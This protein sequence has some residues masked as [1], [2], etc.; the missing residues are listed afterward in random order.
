MWLGWV[1]L[2]VGGFVHGF[3]IGMIEDRIKGG[4]VLIITGIS[5]ALLGMAAIAGSRG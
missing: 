5:L 2:A 1:L 3:G 4:W